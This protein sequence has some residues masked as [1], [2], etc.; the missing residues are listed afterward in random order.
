MGILTLDG[1]TRPP[2]NL[3]TAEKEMVDLPSGV[4]RG[5]AP[6]VSPFWDDTI[7][8]LHSL[9][10]IYLDRKRI[11]FLAKTLFLVFTFRPNTH[12][13]FGEDLFFGF[14]LLLDIILIKGVTS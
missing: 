12:L 5:G 8:L 7:W 1:G 10:I 9:P 11:H 6:R 13:I 3:S 2:Y 14:H 4:A